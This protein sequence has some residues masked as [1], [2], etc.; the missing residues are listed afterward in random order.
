MGSIFS[1]YSILQCAN[2]AQLLVRLQQAILQP[3]ALY[4]ASSCTHCP[5]RQLQSLQHAFLCRA[6]HVKSSVTAEIVFQQLSVTWWHDLWGR[7]VLA[8]WNAMARAG[9]AIATTSNIFLHD[10]LALAQNACS[11]ACHRL[12]R[13]SDALLGICMAS[14]AHGWSALLLKYGLMSCQWLFKWGSRPLLTLYPWTLVL[15]LIWE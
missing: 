13:S 14:P 5:L 1:L 6:C 11:F 15:A 8:F 7:R 3:C 2:S 9:S 4:G 10:A 12:H